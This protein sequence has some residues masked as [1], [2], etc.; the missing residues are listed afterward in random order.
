V[1]KIDKPIKYRLFMKKL[2]FLSIIVILYNSCGKLDGTDYRFK[3]K[4]STSK[5]IYYYDIYTYPDT[6]IGTINIPRVKDN[7]EVKPNSESSIPTQVSWERIFKNDLPS[8]TLVVFIFDGDVIE[9]VPW[10]TIKKKYM[11]LKRYDLSYDDLVRLNWTIN[12]PPTADM[13]IKMYPR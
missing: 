7:Y 10:D 13:K 12:Y 9:K 11:I 3:A 2:I 1:A 6:S 4:N 5:Y 8:D